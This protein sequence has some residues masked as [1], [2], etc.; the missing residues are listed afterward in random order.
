MEL[1][2]GLWKKGCGVNACDAGL[3]L[4][5]RIGFYFVCL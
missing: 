1:G 5:M 4:F 2:L 3:D